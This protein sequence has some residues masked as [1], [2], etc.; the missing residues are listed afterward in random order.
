MAQNDAIQDKFDV[1]LRDYVREHVKHY[2]ETLK[3]DE[4]DQ[5]R[6]FSN[7][8]QDDEVW[9]W[10]GFVPPG[11]LKYT[12]KDTLN[13]DLHCRVA[14]GPRPFEIEPN[15]FDN[16][17]GLDEEIDSSKSVFMQWV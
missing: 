10:F 8:A 12:I 7:E 2:E 1:D 6:S 17:M 14:V 13:K 3:I 15:Y 16:N 9:C 4:L 11:A 5:P